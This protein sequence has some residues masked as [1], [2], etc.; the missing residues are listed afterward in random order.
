[1]HITKA[2]C[3]LALSSLL[4]SSPAMANAQEQITEAE[5]WMKG[6]SEKLMERGSISGTYLSNYM[7]CLKDQHA[8]KNDPNADIEQL[9]KQ[10][11][12]A[13]DSCAPVIDEMFDAL[14]E[15]ETGQNKQQHKDLKDSL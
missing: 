4:L 15:Q 2:A 8:L 1:M 14:E 12:S 10:L 3:A 5:E 13:T 7:Q 6:L 9:W 11:M